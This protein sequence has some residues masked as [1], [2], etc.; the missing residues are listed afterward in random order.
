MALCGPWVDQVRLCDADD[1][2]PGDLDRAIEVAS[3][4]LYT[5]TESRWPGICTD[6]V[7][8]CTT[9]GATQMI[10]NPVG[11]GSRPLPVGR[12]GGS[13]W[14]GGSPCSCSS[15][16]LSCGCKDHPNVLLPGRPVVDVVEV[17]IDGQ[18]FHDY[19][20]VDDRW[21]VRTDGH[22]WACCQDLTKPA[23][24]LGTWEITYEYG[25]APP[26]AG[27]IAAEAL[28]CELARSWQPGDTECRLPRRL[29]QLTR[30]GITMTVM[31][32]F[33]FLDE[34]RF[35]IYEVDA[36]VTAANQGRKPGDTG[37]RVLMAS[38]LNA[39]HRVRW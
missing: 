37:G 30:E 19:V 8:P 13:D 36:F 15:D 23:T 2:E 11:E 1:F 34:G 31:D 32:P 33:D 27:R 38:D 35:G 24:E 21:L 22:Q 18:P 3:W 5:G 25:S 14:W 28:A 39:I 16:I 4:L 10:Q 12:W 26:L 9:S 17:L 6:T 7:R 20:I 29:T